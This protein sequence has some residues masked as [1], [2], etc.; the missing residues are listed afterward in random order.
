MSPE[1]STMTILASHDRK[2]C[3]L[4]KLARTRKQDRVSSERA[5]L[6]TQPKMPV[7]TTAM[8]IATGAAIAAR[9]TSSEMCAVAS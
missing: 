5:Y 2:C 9:F 7:L 8:Q 6:R 3:I 1:T 4:R